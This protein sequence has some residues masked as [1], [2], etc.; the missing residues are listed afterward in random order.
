MRLTDYLTLWTIV[1]RKGLPAEPFGGR[2]TLFLVLSKEL[3]LVNTHELTLGKNVPF[4]GVKELF[5]RCARL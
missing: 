2:C 4:Y 1:P 5:L 3:T